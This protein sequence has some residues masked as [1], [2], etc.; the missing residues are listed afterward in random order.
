[1]EC[2]LKRDDTG[3]IVEITDPVLAEKWRELAK[4]DNYKMPSEP[5]FRAAGHCFIIYAANPDGAVLQILREHCASIINHLLEKAKL[6][7][8]DPTAITD[9]FVHLL[10][11]A[12]AQTIMGDNKLSSY[13]YFPHPFVVYSETKQGKTIQPKDQPSNEENLPKIHDSCCLVC[14]KY[15]KRAKTQRDARQDASEH[16]KTAHKKSTFVSPQTEQ[17]GIRWKL[18]EYLIEILRSRRSNSAA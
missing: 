5:R 17:H 15:M 4:Y 2:I 6:P 7:Q 3:E 9:P 8:I 18:D 16:F 14:P 1:M 12:A 13:I 10:C 11:T